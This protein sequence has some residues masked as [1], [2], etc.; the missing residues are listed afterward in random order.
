MKS[1]PKTLH[2]LLLCLLCLVDAP[3]PPIM[4]QTDS[5]Q[6]NSINITWSP[7]AQEALGGPVTDYLAQIKRNG[8]NDPWYNCSSSDTLESTFC[9]FTSL[10]KDTSYEVRVMA[11][12]R[13]GYGLP[14]HK[15]IKTKITGNYK[16][17]LSIKK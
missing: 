8:S 10:K 13:V 12:N 14:S 7:P 9:L 5:G 3:Y 15:I 6:C 11:K 1:E 4:F 17:P 2:K 16:T